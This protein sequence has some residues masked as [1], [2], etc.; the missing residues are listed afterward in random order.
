MRDEALAYFTDARST[1]SA[2]NFLH[3]TLDGVSAAGDGENLFFIFWAPGA[4]K[5]AIAPQKVRPE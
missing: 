1:M 3:L 5:A 2:Q 4:R